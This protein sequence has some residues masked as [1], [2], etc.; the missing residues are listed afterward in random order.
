MKAPAFDY[1]KPRSLAEVFELMAV[2]G[3]SARLLAGGQTLLATL[4]M[5]LSE[6][7][8]LID[9]NG[10]DA[11]KGIS[12]QGPVLRIGA[13]VTHTEIEASALVARHAPLLSMAAPYIA[14]RAIR[15]LGTWGG[16]IA[17]ADPA[18]EWPTCL[19]ALE[20]VV[21]LRGAGGERRVPAQ[22]FFIDLYSTALAEGEIVAACEVPLSD[23]RSVFVFDELARRHGDYAIVGLALAAQR[24]G[25]GLQ[26]VRLAF[27]GVGNTPLRVRATEALFTGQS[28]T[29]ALLDA[30]TDSL[31]TELNPMPDLT[32][33][34]A[35]KRHLA[36]VLARR[37][38]LAT[39]QVAAAT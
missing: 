4:N 17:Y 27:L 38:L 36:C 23:S 15:N 14:H 20:G 28:I 25:D 13:L 12:V 34:S 6:P 19:A 26:R 5:R 3:D 39:R 33:S 10:I 21:V 16:S 31:K 29:P 37:A 18:A 7:A 24:A 30:A 32:H 1:A 22:D 2:H 35:T 8:L 11:L 9:I